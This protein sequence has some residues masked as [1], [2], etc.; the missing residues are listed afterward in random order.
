MGPRLGKHL[1]KSL[2][3]LCDSCPPG[4]RRKVSVP[5]FTL[6]LFG[7]LLRVG[8]NLMY[9]LR[10]KWGVLIMEYL[11][12]YWLYQLIVK[13]VSC[14]WMKKSS[15]TTHCLDLNSMTN[16]FVIATHSTLQ[17]SLKSQI[18]MYIH[19]SSH[20]K[21]REII[22]SFTQIT[23][24]WPKNVLENYVTSMDI[25]SQQSLWWYC[26]WMNELII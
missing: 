26:Y 18:H 8:D 9:C 4:G 24:H 11:Y 17:K 23:L 13:N 3:S 10:D 6:I 5:Y 2:G 15:K 22:D 20:I 14:N 7:K 21:G 16:R 1:L 19:W 12:D 25:C